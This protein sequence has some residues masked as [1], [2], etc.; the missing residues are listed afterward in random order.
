MGYNRVVTASN[1]VLRKANF[2]LAL[3][4]L[5]SL[6]FV[7]ENVSDAF[8]KARWIGGEVLTDLGEVLQ[9]DYFD[10][11]WWDDQQEKAISDLGDLFEPDGAVSFIGEDDAQW[12]WRVNHKGHSFVEVGVSIKYDSVDP[13]PEFLALRGARSASD[14]PVPKDGPWNTVT[15]GTAQYH[16][17]GMAKAHESLVISTVIAAIDPDDELDM[18]QVLELADGIKEYV[19]A[20]REESD[21]ALLEVVS[22]SAAQ[23]LM[24]WRSTQRWET[25]T[26]NVAKALVQSELPAPGP[27]GP[28]LTI[29]Q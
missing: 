19:S 17:K 22:E 8:E 9:I 1:L 11:D 7:G 12:A 25:A 5:R 28:S 16:L 23:Y 29:G 26:A 4:R 10:G 2:E 15:A 20:R 6:G 27:I 18:E 14:L 21:L 13:T 3:E 24:A